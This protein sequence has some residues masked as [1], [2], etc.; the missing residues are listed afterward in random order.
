MSFTYTGTPDTTTSQ[1]RLD[2]VRLLVKDHVEST[3]V[4][5]D[6]EILFFLTQNG[7][8]IYRA[9]ADAADQLAGGEA[10]SKSVGDLSITNSAVAWMDIARAYRRKAALGAIPY[11]GGIS[12]ADKDAYEADTDRVEPAFTR[13][14][15]ED[16]SVG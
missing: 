13:A 9:A 7:N 10:G 8:S 14:T 4:F 15:H 16:E 2:A 12:K 3:H 1:G 6:D 11:A 5:E